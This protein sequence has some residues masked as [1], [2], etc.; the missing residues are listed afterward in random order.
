MQN[1][2]NALEGGDVKKHNLVVVDVIDGRNSMANVDDKIP[3]LNVVIK[4]HSTFIAASAVDFDRN[5]HKYFHS[6][7]VVNGKV[8]QHSWNILNNIVS[9]IRTPSDQ[10]AFR[11]DPILTRYRLPPPLSVR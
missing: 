1:D 7:V 4:A 5:K 3:H 10:I 8:Q 9:A 6:D 11:Y 2:I